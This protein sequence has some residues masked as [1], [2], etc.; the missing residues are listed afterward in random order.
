MC[1]KCSACPASWKS[2]CQSSGPPIGFITSITR[3]G[4]SIGEQKARGLLSGRSSTSR[5]MFSCRRRSMPSPAS[6]ASRAGSICSFGNCGSHCGARYSR[7]TSH[8]R[9]SSRPIP[10]RER[11]R[12]SAACSYSF[13]VASR[14][15][16]AL[17]R[18]LVQRDGEAPVQLDVAVPA[19]RRHGRMGHRERLHVHR[20]EL[21]LE[22]LGA[23]A[24]QPL[25]PRAVRL[26]GDRRPHLAQRDRA[27]RPPPP[28]ARP[29][30]RR[31]SPRMSA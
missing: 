13:S 10:S 18:R 3:C 6:V 24:L 22:K 25:A 12:R 16:P 19:E 9:A 5:W 2:A 17:L 1:A 23:G 4:T 31:A 14:K 28:R 29:R 20:I 11:K 26:V 8:A 21:V 30:A 27:R 7:A 15:R